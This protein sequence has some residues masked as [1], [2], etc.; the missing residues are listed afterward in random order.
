MDYI[1]KEFIPGN[2]AKLDGVVIS[3]NWAGQ[4]A[5]GMEGALTGIEETIAF[6]KHYNIKTVIIGQTERYTVPYP[7]VMARN[8]MYGTNNNTFYLDGYTQKMNAFLNANLK[9]TYINVLN[10]AAF[11]PLSNSGEPYMRDKDH[12]TKYG[13]DLIVEKLKKDPVW[14]RFLGDKAQ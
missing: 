14:R 2:A 10:Q 13:A 11:P 4:R 1:F 6:L 5:I 8:Y 7:V 12:A 9:G 3:G